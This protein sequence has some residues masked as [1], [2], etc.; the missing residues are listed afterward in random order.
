MT[1]QTTFSVEVTYPD[2]RVAH[3]WPRPRTF[4]EA[5]ERAAELE[6]DGALRV[7]IEQEHDLGMPPATARHS[8]GAHGYGRTLVAQLPYHLAARRRLER[9]VAAERR[10]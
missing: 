5:L 10:G 7:Y 6:R 1:T 2:G 9:A 8:R 4:T 3:S